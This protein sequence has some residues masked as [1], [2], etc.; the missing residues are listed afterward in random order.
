MRN[1]SCWA[2]SLGD[3]SSKLSREHIITEKLFL[4]HSEIRIDNGRFAGIG[5]IRRSAFASK[6][7]C[8]A[9]N[10]ALS[11]VDAE[12][13]RLFEAFKTV[14]ANSSADLPRTDREFTFDTVLLERWLTKTLANV[15]ASG[16]F[17]FDPPIPQ[18]EIVI[19][20]KSVD[21]IFGRAKYEGFAGA[22]LQNRL[23]ALNQWGDHY[24]ITPVTTQVRRT[25]GGMVFR[26]VAIWFVLWIT[27]N[28]RIHP[29]VLMLKNVKGYSLR[30]LPTTFE[31]T[32]NEVSRVQLRFK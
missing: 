13:I 16:A 18:R 25:T 22:Y 12:A 32:L 15:I 24:D 28:V 29:N 5:A 11:P 7:L 23:E 21:V 31:F 17:E 6:V 27:S 9:H 19:D 3:C 4:P 30:K 1:P 2:N 8:K 20:S 10:E 14:H 26:F